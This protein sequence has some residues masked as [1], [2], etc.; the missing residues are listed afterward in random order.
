MTSIAAFGLAVMSLLGP[1]LEVV[2]GLRRG[3]ARLTPAD[4][5][6]Q[7]TLDHEYATKHKTG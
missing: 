5:C 6:R 2:A 3:H 4:V 1:G 7:L